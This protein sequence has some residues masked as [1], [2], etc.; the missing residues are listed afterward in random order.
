MATITMTPAQDA[1]LVELFIDAPPAR[2]FEA[3][4]DPAQVLQWWG[5]EGMY[6]T[7]RWQG[8]LRVGGSWRSEGL[9]ADGSAFHV[10]GEYLEVDTPRLLVY[11][12]IASWTGDLKTTVRWELTPQNGGTLLK[13][14]HSGFAGNTHAAQDHSNGWQRVL[15]WMQAFVEKGDTIDSRR[16][17]SK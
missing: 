7:T 16:P 9:G 1:I 13:V 11:T 14:R 4:S 6:R 17:L 8:D 3:I 2:V 15:G 10:S 5:Q 12:W